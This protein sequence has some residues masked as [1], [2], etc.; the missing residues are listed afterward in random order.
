VAEVDFEGQTFEL[1]TGKLNGLVMMEF[2]A[3]TAD[4]SPD[5]DVPADVMI[6][7]LE[8]SIADKDWARFR[9]L[10][11]KTDDFWEKAMSTVFKARVDAAAEATGDFPTGLPSDSSDGPTTTEQKSELS[12]EDKVL[13]LALGRPD[14]LAMLR[15]L[16]DAKPQRRR[17]AS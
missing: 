1:K 16:Q 5:A 6:A 7:L 17:R 8:E 2:A 14:R 10:G 4:Q 12:S 3:A 13:E 9:K 11:R 15:D